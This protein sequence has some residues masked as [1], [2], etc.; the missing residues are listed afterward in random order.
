MSLWLKSPAAINFADVDAFCQ[1][2]QPEGA[3]LDYKGISFPKDLAKTIAAFGNTMGGLILLG[4]DADKISNKPIWP[5][6][7]GMPTDVGLQERV[8]QI[9]HDAIY[10][11]VRV[12]VSDAIENPNLPGHVVLVIRVNESREA[13]HAVEKNRKVYVYERTAN[14][15]EPYELADM[16]RIEHLLRRRS[17]LVESREAELQANLNRAARHMHRSE[18]PIRWMSVAPVYPWKEL[19]DP[20]TCA[21]FHQQQSFPLHIWNGARWSFQNCVGGSFGAAR[22]DRQN[23]TPVCVAVSS[24]SS[25]GTIFCMGYAEEATVDNGTLLMPDENPVAANMWMNHRNIREMAAGLLEGCH[26]FYTQSKNPP[27]EIMF[28]IGINNAFRLFMQDS[29]KGRKS[30]A[31]YI[32][33]EFRIDQVLDSQ[34][35]LANRMESLTTMFDD[36]SFAFNADAVVR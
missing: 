7:E 19:H 1:T 8:Y 18:C 5:A 21:H 24:V 14:K 13:P 15:S 16:D 26:H 17:Q 12:A 20:Y 27:G 30:D 29:L 36:I 22:I 31:P 28:S 23:S 10:P 6:T 34:N 9:A 4:V 32:D 2:M 33:P 25:N 11:P 3:R 35:I